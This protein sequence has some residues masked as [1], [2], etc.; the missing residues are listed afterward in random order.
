MPL[1]LALPE[2]AAAEGDGPTCPELREVTPLYS[3]YS[4]EK[5]SL[6]DSS[7]RG[8]VLLGGAIGTPDYCRAHVETRLAEG[9]K[10]MKTAHSMP[11][12]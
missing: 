7:S 9:L 5:T 1:L 6:C 4:K 11:V 3:N 12:S 8:L 2:T 10:Q